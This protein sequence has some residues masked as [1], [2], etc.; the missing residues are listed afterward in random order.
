MSPDYSL[1]KSDCSG[2]DGIQPLQIAINIPAGLLQP[3]PVQ[4]GPAGVGGVLQNDLGDVLVIL[5]EYR[6]R[7]S[8]EDEVVAILEALH[9]FVLY[10]LL[11]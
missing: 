9:F 11:L 6:A 2:M 4:P 3:F 8:N 5:S 1:T 7:E 10:P